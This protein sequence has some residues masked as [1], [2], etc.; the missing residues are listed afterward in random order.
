MWLIHSACFPLQLI[1]KLYYRKVKAAFLSK[2]N[3]QTSEK[4][5]RGCQELLHAIS[6]L[7]SSRLLCWCV[8]PTAHPAPLWDGLPLR[9]HSK[10]NQEEEECT[11][12]QRAW[13]LSLFWWLMLGHRHHFPLL[14]GFIAVPPPRCKKYEGQVSGM[15]S[16]NVIGSLRINIWGLWLLTVWTFPVEEVYA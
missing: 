2:G 12:S 13:D 14:K 8:C 3:A 15:P 7:L 4:W 6:T 11:R 16:M 10:S 1:R 9:V 5:E